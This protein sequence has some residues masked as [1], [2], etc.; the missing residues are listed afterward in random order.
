MNDATHWVEP[1]HGIRIPYEVLGP[2]R[3]PRMLFA[4]ALTATGLGL[5]EVFQPLLDAGWTVVSMDQRGHGRATSTTDPDDYS[6]QAMGGDL[7]AI[8]DDLGWETAWLAGGSMGAAPAMAAAT[9]AP[10]RVEGLLLIA[11][12][13]GDAPNPSREH[14]REIADAFEHGGLTAGQRAWRRVMIEREVPA[15][16]VDAHVERLEVHDVGGLACWLRVIPAWTL[17]DEMGAIDQLPFPVVTLAWDDDEIHPAD[18]ARRI[19]GAAPAGSF[20]TIGDD[21]KDPFTLFRL[22]LDA[23]EEARRR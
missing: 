6:P 3:H 1:A 22:A 13:F 23:V 17:P 9:S 14:F 11:P 16:V 7:L 4:H 8:M 12:A 19:A 21:E 10:E 5:R 20:R 2:G 15:D 18:L